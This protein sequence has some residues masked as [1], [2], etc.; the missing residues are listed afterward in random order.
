MVMMEFTSVV[1]PADVPPATTMF[2]WRSTASIRKSTWDAVIV[3]PFTISS[4]ENTLSD[5]FLI[6]IPSLW[7]AGGD[8]KFALY[9]T[10]GMTPSRT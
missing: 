7:T 8:T 5:G 6:V 4:I 3:P 10:T 1:F 2:A 9:P